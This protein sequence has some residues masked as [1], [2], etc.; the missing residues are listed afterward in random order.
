MNGQEYQ[1]LSDPKSQEKKGY[2]T[3]GLSQ[4]AKKKKRYRSG[5]PPLDDYWLSDHTSDEEEENEEEENES[6]EPIGR[7]GTQGEDEETSFDPGEDYGAIVNSHSGRRIHTGARRTDSF[8]VEYS[9]SSSAS[10]AWYAWLCCCCSQQNSG[11]K[12]ADKR[13][14]KW[15]KMCASWYRLS[16]A[17]RRVLLLFMLYLIQIG[18]AH[19]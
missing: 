3:I 15:R 6:E 5:E 4:S 8:S 1:L 9:S 2:V 14:T 7:R 11:T 19:V 12:R 16:V 17:R 10:A 13:G 18:R